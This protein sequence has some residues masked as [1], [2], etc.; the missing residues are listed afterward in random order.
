MSTDTQHPRRRRLPRV[1]AAV[2]ALAS[3]VALAACGAN[4]PGTDT[5]S[6][7]KSDDVK[8]T[9]GSG[10]KIAMVT[11]GDSGAYWSIVKRG[12]EA[13]AKDLGIELNYAESAND[14]Q[15]QAQL[16]EAAITQKPD[17]LA[18]SAPNPDAI[19]GAVK[20]ATA[21]GIPVV[22]LNSGVEKF[23]ELGAIAGVGQDPTIAGEAVGS[24]LKKEGVKK[25]LCVNH[26]QSNVEL[27]ARCDGV[28]QG[29]GGGGFETAN[30]AGNKDVSTSTNEIKS[31][32]QAD[33]AIDAVVT[34][35]PE[36]ALATKSAVGSS[37]RKVKIAT[38]DLSGDIA[39]A[40]QDGSVE[41]AVDQQPYLQGY[42]PM[43][44]F[45]LYK[46]TGTVVGGGRTVLTGPGIVDA[47]NAA[48]VEKLAADGIR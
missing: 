13:G 42:L 39:K 30:V 46:S 14:P 40:I 21:A 6:S 2:A 5:G 12:A 47:K 36:M 32:L 31:K 9:A 19:K 8:L 33:S 7:G 4:G 29:L 10:L 23:A 26:E 1:G 34:L 24:R 20:Q 37:G 28:K 18:V 41:F 38:F 35:D 3:A 48:Q 43:T 17:G 44:L 25:I 16:I 27:Q 45:K 22:V 15:K 11:H